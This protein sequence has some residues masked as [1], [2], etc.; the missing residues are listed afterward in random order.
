MSSM[1]FAARSFNQDI[2]N[3]DTSS[4]SNMSSMFVNADNFNQNIENWDV[5]NVIQMSS[6]FNDA[7]NF[8]QN[9]G[10]WIFNQN[11]SMLSM[12]NR[13]GMDCNNYSATLVG[14]EENNPT[15]TNKSLGALGRNY[16]VSAVEARNILR[17]ERGWTFS[18]DSASSE[19]CDALLSTTDFNLGD[20]VSIYPNPSAHDFTLEFHTLH[21]NIHLEVYNI[22]GQLILNK[23][24][25][26]VNDIKLNI[27]TAGMYFLKV[28]ADDRTNTFKLIR[29]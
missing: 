23:N 4:V 20:Q 16:G 15:V 19:A 10:R 7:D 3:W 5:S 26:N 21:E 29:Y 2:G 1:F 18:G 13:C 22:N 9:L 24:Y 11:V 6:M 27:E 17:F 12:L 25:Q 14:W 28:Y 8:N